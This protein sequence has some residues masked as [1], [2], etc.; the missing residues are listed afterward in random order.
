VFEPFI[1]VWATMTRGAAAAR[2]SIR[3]AFER[4]LF[5]RPFVSGARA[6]RERG[7]PTRARIP[8]AR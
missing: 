7:Y 3:A 4:G 5:T 8:R 6:G 1:A 2:A